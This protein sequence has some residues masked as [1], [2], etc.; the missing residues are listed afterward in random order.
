MPEAV[1][2]ID[3]RI[4]VLAIDP[5]A[6]EVLR[7]PYPFYAHLRAL[8]PVFWVEKYGLYG[9][10][11]HATVA[12]MLKDWQHFTSTRG[13][14]MS[15]ITQP[16]AWRD[17]GLLVEQDPPVHTGLR[18]PMH[19]VMTVQRLLAWKKDLAAAAEA[20]VDEVLARGEVDAV[21]AMAEAF[22]LK[23]FTE[24]LGVE[25][26][27]EAM[28]VIGDWNLN[29]L[30]PNN[31]V[32]KDSAARAALY[33]DWLESTAAAESQQSGG[34]GS[35]FYQAEAEGLIA[36]GMA[37]QIVR[38]LLRAGVD[39]TIA[40]MGVTL[41]NLARY[42][43]QYDL[44]REN[45]KLIGRAVEESLRLETPP[46]TMFRTTNEGAAIDGIPL[47]SGIKVQFWLAAANRDPAVW[48]DPDRFDV[49][50]PTSASLAFGAGPH[51]CFGN[52]VAKLEIEAL[53][54]AL[55][56]RVR[57]FELAA[58]PVFKLTNVTRTLQTM[59]VRL[60]A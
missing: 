6:E 39:T 50:R 24:L 51:T 40:G 35:A 2:E 4:P 15:D 36:P 12:A 20:L 57:R 48:P 59:P 55:T 17:K 38:T 14:G 9:T 29:T 27:W 1:L 16:G 32:T 11:R 5:F 31:Q 30:G 25:A 49:T 18:R 28:L 58:E 56:S 52:V 45:P 21:P 3:S 19:Q 43:D 8:G 47:R 13:V 60:T 7:D 46:T 10:A 54:T 33:K 22:V 37:Y 41:M 42:P 23:T 53:V 44:L 34:V 26:N